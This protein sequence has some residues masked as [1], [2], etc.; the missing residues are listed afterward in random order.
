M[1][2][3]PKRVFQNPLIAYANFEDGSFVNLIQ[4]RKPYANGRS[5]AV[6]VANKNPLCSNGMFSTFKRGMN[7]FNLMVRTAMKETKIIKQEFL[8]SNYISQ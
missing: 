7:K 8:T 4:L 2:N 6:Y 5:F 1:K 3:L